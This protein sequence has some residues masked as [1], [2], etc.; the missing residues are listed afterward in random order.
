MAPSMCLTRGVLKTPFGIN[1][2]DL[3]TFLSFRLQRTLRDSCLGEGFLKG[4]M[5]HDYLD[6]KNSPPAFSFGGNWRIG[7][8]Q[9]K[10]LLA[11]STTATWFVG[12]PN[13]VGQRRTRPGSNP[14][15]SQQQRVLSFRNGNAAAFLL[16]VHCCICFG[17]VFVRLHQNP[18]NP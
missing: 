8:M 3:R 11:T 6:S 14:F 17:P 5:Y 10:P 18:T 4:L 7:S 15:H 9:N 16:L 12:L 13:M 1:H 2:L